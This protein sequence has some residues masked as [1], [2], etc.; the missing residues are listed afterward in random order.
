MFKH[1]LC[2]YVAFLATYEQ[3]VVDSFINWATLVWVT[4][5]QVTKVV[6]LEANRVLR[7]AMCV[8]CVYGWCV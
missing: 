3:Y 2:E 4:A 6:A 8:V 1:A 7:R 5:D